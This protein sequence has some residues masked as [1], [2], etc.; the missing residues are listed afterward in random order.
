MLKLS[1]LTLEQQHA[2]FTSTVSVCD[3]IIRSKESS[4]PD[5][6]VHVN[7]GKFGVYRI[8]IDT[9]IDGNVEKLVEASIIA[10][11]STFYFLNAREKVR[12]TAM[13]CAKLIETRAW[14]VQCIENIS[15]IE[16]SDQEIEFFGK[17]KFMFEDLNKQQLI[18]AQERMNYFKDDVLN[19]FRNIEN[20]HTL[21]GFSK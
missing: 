9:M 4:F 14:Y 20:V 7:K 12:P 19:V 21:L 6:A 2:L 13:G 15:T 17:S 10:M 8:L 11:L 18:E 3:L 16:Q 5:D 1:A